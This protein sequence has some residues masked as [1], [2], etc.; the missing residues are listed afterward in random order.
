MGCTSDGES[1]LIKTVRGKKYLM[2]KDYNSAAKQPRCKLLFADQYLTVHVGDLWTDIKTTGL[3]NEG[4]VE[5]KNGKKPEK[6]IERIIRLNTDENDIVL[7]SFLGSGTTSA[8]A[9]KMNRRWIGIEM[10][11]QALTHCK[12]R[13]DNVVTGADQGGI[14]QKWN[15]VGGGGYR[16][17]ELAPTLINIDKFGEPVISDLY[18]ADM[19]AASVAVHEGFKYNPDQRLFWKQSQSTE[20]SFLFVTTKYIDSKYLEAIVSTMNDDEYLVIAC[21]AY[22]SSLES[23]FKNLNIKKIPEMLLGKCDFG[24]DDYSLNIINPPIYYEEDENYEE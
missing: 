5:F 13:L 4:T 16:Y 14:S 3:T 18:N 9:H 2:K 8:V 11:E 6:L 22:D 20:K 10:G 12:V 15:W 24:K 7:D 19:L 1:F 17:Y 23:K 21:K